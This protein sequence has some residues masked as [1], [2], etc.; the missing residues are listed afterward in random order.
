MAMEDNTVLPAATPAGA[1]AMSPQIQ[2]F[3]NLLMGGGLHGFGSFGGLPFGGFGQ[4]LTQNPALMR[5]LGLLHEAGFPGAPSDTA[6]PAGQ[7]FSASLVQAAPPAAT[8]PDPTATLSASSDTN[9]LTGG[10]PGPTSGTPPVTPPGGT[11]AF[12]PPANPAPL[13]PMAGG[14][15]GQASNPLFSL[16]APLLRK[17]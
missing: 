14:P 1:G 9:V 6:A 5:G 8:S 15:T 7:G 3:L 13:P 12:N 17:G 4:F 16:M 11:L 10:A 2:A